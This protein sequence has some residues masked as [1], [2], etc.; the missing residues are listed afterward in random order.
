MNTLRNFRK[1]VAEL[2][3]NTWKKIHDN[4]VC[5]II[6]LGTIC[7]CFI[8]LIAKDM[9]HHA[10]LVDMHKQHTIIENSWSNDRELLSSLVKD[11]DSFIKFQNEIIQNQ[12][13]NLEEAVITIERQTT[14]LNQLIDY[15][16]K[17]KHWPPKSPPEDKSRFAA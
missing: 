9:N 2:L 5:T 3:S 8:M 1:W 6:V 13:S 16:K 14:I 17:I 12:R 11:K 15:L 7:V 4:Y 10:K